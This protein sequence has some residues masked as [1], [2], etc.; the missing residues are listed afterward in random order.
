MQVRV[1]PA[2]IVP[3]ER[4]AVGSEPLVQL[5]SDEKQQFPVAAHSP[6]VIAPVMTPGRRIASDA[7]R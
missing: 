7:P 2:L 6:A 4:V 3:A 1:E 5:G